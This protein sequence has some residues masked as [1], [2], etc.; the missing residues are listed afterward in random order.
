MEKYL[1]KDVIYRSKTG[2]GS[3]IRSWVRN[4]LKDFI[5]EILCE[6]NI[7]KRNIFNYNFIKNL[8]TDNLEYNMMPLHYFP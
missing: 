4:D 5:N 1:P 8:I 6:S 3:P 7:K 2:F